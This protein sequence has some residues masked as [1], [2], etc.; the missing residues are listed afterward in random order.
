[1]LT[2]PEGNPIP[3]D[4]PRLPSL[5]DIAAIKAEADKGQAVIEANG[6]QIGP[7]L[8]LEAQVKALVSM[9]VPPD[10]NDPRARIFQVRRHSHR[11]DTLRT[12]IQEMQEARTGP[13]LLIPNGTAI[14]KD[15]RAPGPG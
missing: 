3:A 2:D 9:F 12:I 10:E 11:R 15:L 4:D 13:R 7:L 14:P 1:M 5:E 6:G 8:D